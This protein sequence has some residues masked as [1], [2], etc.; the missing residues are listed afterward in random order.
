M[1]APKSHLRKK[2]R[3]PSLH[4]ASEEPSL[5]LRRGTVRLVPNDPRWKGAFLREKRRIRRALGPFARDF[6]H[7]GSTAIPG[8][9]AKPILDIMAAVP[10]L[11]GLKPH[12]GS[13]TSLGYEYLGAR[14]ARGRRFLAKGPDARRTVHLH[15]TT[16]QS[17]FWIKHL[18]FRDYL[19]GHAEAVHE[20]ATLKRRLARRHGRDRDKYT[21]GKASFV[22]KIL[23]RAKALPERGRQRSGRE[24]P[25]SLLI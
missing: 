19:R 8:V 25:K 18:L 12:A 7:V 5:G 15:L 21:E 4:R 20:Y 9:P 24:G 13:L 6:E 1:S 22:R 10:S 23:R 3:S 17:P 14:G 2:G 11:E 16:K